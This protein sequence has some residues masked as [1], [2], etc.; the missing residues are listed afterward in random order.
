VYDARNIIYDKRGALGYIV[1]KKVDAT[2]TDS[3][4]E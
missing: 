1:S 2:G 3:L 4:T